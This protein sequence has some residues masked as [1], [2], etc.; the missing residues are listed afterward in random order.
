MSAVPRAAPATDSRRVARL[1]LMHRF[2]LPL[3]KAVATSSALNLSIAL[4]GSLAFFLSARGATVG[5]ASAH[6][7]AAL[8]LAAGAI[9]SV[10]LGVFVSQRLP[11][12]VFRRAVGAVNVIA[13]VTL[14]LQIA[15]G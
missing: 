2:A 6:V 4:G 13:A 1:V 9:A 11:T 10:P 15:R 12:F 5:T 3:R 14:L 8:L 7:A